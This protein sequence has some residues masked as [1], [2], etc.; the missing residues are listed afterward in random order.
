MKHYLP[1]CKAHWDLLSALIWRLTGHVECVL[2]CVTFFE[3]SKSLVIYLSPT[4]TLIDVLSHAVCLA[5]FHCMFIYISYLNITACCDICIH[6]KIQ[7][8][9]H[10]SILVSNFK[11]CFV[12]RD[13]YLYTLTMTQS[14]ITYLSNELI[15]ITESEQCKFPLAM[16]ISIFRWFGISRCSD[17]PEIFQ[18][19]FCENCKLRCTSF[20]I[21]S[22]G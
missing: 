17:F 22:F 14:W 21:L 3:K 6:T 1:Q 16:C 4:I 15:F 2:C 8:L 13:E 10:L 11:C 9:H 7:C 12:C 5:V 18:N 20:M 19:L